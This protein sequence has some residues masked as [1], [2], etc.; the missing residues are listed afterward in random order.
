[1]IRE[2]ARRDAKKNLFDAPRGAENTGGLSSFHFATAQFFRD[3]PH[4]ATADRYTV[5]RQRRLALSRQFLVNGEGRR[6][7]FGRQ[8][9]VIGERRTAVFS[10]QFWVFSERRRAKGLS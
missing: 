5:K 8:F 4:F 2:G 1:M 7:V 6:A 3:Q 9:L 10:G